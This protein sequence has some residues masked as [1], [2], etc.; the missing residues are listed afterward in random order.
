MHDVWPEASCQ[1]F[2]HPTQLLWLLKA[3]DVPAAHDVQLRSEVALPQNV[4]YVPPAHTRHV[5]HAA[6]DS[7]LLNVPHA[8]AA[9]VASTAPLHP[10]TR[11]DP[12][13]HLL[14]APQLRSVDE[15]PLVV[16]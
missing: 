6:K 12:A 4:V 5:V 10:L 8:H 1:L 14:H 13:A 3:C 2:V 7:P 9:Q 11:P 15:V 16:K